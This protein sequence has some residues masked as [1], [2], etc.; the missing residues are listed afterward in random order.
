MK[1][2]LIELNHIITEG[3]ETYK[4]LPGPTI[5]DYFSHEES[6]KLY[7]DGTEFQIGRIDMVSNTG[8]YLDVPFH[9]YKD[10]EDL[11]A[12][13][14]EKLADLPG[15]LIDARMWP[16]G[17]PPEAVIGRKV[18]G[19]AVLFLTGWDQHWGHENYFSGHPFLEAE[20]ADYLLSQDVTLVGIDSHNIDDTSG[21]TRPVHTKLLGAGVPIV[22]HMCG[23][24]QLFGKNFSF[25]AA[26]PRIKGMGTFPV[27]AFAKILPDS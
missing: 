9:R 10:R 17:I 24:D 20:T 25:T 15:T 2:R 22:E 14:L 4:G 21:N 16:N 8:T 18:S 5:C 7:A 6:R 12:V 3:M 1:T 11:S 19:K 23:L 26:P 13:G 27:R